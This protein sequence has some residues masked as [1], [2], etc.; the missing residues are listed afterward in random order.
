[1][2]RTGLGGDQVQDGSLTGA[3]LADYSVGLSKIVQGTP[4]RVLGFDLDGRLVELTITN[5]SVYYPVH[6]V[7]TQVEAEGVVTLNVPNTPLAVSAHGV[8][9]EP[10]VDRLTWTGE[11]LPP[12]V[13]P[14][15]WVARSI[16]ASYDAQTHVLSVSVFGP[17][18]IV[19]IYNA[20]PL[21]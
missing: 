13:V 10:S 19:A 8:P 1:M 18:V 17:T 21:A 7:S 20:P 14:E 16:T 2:S 9:L 4:G 12:E 15:G 11:E 6:G 3:D 5:A